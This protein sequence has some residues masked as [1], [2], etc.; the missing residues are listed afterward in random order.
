M[1][2]ILLYMNKFYILILIVLFTSIGL[3]YYNQMS[4]SND[5]TGVDYPELQIN[6]ADED[7]VC[8]VDND[9]TA[10]NTSC[11]SIYEWWAKV[12]RES[13]DKYTQILEDCKKEYPGK[14]YTDWEF[15][16]LRA[17]DPSGQRKTI[18]LNKV[19]TQIN[20]KEEVVVANLDAVMV[21]QIAED[22]L[23]NKGYDIKLLRVPEI[24]YYDEQNEWYYV[25][26]FVG[27]YEK[28]KKDVIG[29]GCNS[30][31]LTIDDSSKSV[32]SFSDP[33]NFQCN[34]VNF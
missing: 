19:C 18:C 10:I 29:I 21:K 11:A 32:E 31:V 30:I 6:I 3:Y 28:N 33:T 17:F 7:L 8:S 23:V 22:Y 1:P 24:N 2:R 34:G 20:S 25:T 27:L 16:N 12:N 14:N 9:C 13:K 15:S 5:L 4:V 26:Q